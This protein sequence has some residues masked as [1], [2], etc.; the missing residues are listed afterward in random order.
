MWMHLL[1]VLPNNPEGKATFSEVTGARYWI[2]GW[3]LLEGDSLTIKSRLTDGWSG[4]VVRNFPDVKGHTEAKEQ[5]AD[6]LCR[7]IMGF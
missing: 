5:L 2:E 6:R 3:F 4:D 1:G 7:R